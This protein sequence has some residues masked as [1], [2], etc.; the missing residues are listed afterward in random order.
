M[1]PVGIGPEMARETV[2]KAWQGRHH[3]PRAGAAR[4]DTVPAT[5][6]ESAPTSQGSSGSS[7]GSGLAGTKRVRPCSTTVATPAILPWAAHFRSAPSA[8]DALA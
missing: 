4:G 6:L 2:T 8:L 7:S 5:V 1:V 3:L